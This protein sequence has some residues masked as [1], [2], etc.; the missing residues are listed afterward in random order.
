MIDPI[1]VAIKNILQKSE[2]SLKKKIPISTVPT[3]PI[4]VHTAYAVPNGSVCVARYKRYMLKVRLIKKPA[5][6]QADVVPV[7]AFAFARQ[8]VNPTSNRPAIIR[9]I[10]FM[11]QKYFMA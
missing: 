9:I 2:G 10:Q 11:A 6:H 4:P 5:S 1:N 8:E 7:V 3:A